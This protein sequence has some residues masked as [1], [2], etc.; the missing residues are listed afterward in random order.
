LRFDSTPGGGSIHG[1][2]VD[3]AAEAVVVAILNGSQPIPLENERGV[4]GKGNGRYK[5]CMR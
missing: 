4:V 3:C 2:K 1:V 5:D